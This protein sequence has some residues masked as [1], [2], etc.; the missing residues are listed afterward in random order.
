MDPRARENAGAAGGILLSV[1]VGHRR[2]RI[3]QIQSRTPDFL[4]PKTVTCVQP[5]KF[6]KV[7]GVFRLG[8]QAVTAPVTVPRRTDGWGRGGATTK[9]D[10]IGVVFRVAQRT[11]R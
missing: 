8:T 3:L 6:E 4:R 10:W 9:A 2:G 5:L 1:E 11:R 7:M